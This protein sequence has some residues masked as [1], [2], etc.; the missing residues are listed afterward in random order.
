MG[1]GDF[2]SRKPRL[3]AADRMELGCFSLCP[4]RRPCLWTALLPL[5]G[6]S[7][8]GRLCD[9]TVPAPSMWMERSRRTRQSDVE[10]LG[11][12]SREEEETEA[13]EASEKCQNEA[14]G[15]RGRDS[16]EGK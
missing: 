16:W 11:E 15:E 8:H 5:T 10:E 4:A 2:L 12:R 3:R 1:M 9:I 13:E 6:A 7:H 14:R